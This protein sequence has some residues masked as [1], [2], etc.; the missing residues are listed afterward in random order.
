MRT[1]AEINEL[2]AALAKAQ[3]E[4]KPAS[5]DTANTFFKTKY[6]TLASCWDACRVALAS[7]GLAVIQSPRLKHESEDHWLVELETRL[8]H[9]S[10]QWI[11]DVLSV[12]VSKLD[13]QG[14]GSA[15]T[16]ARRYSLCAFVGVAPDDDD[17]GESAVGRGNGHSTHSRPTQQPKASPKPPP[18]EDPIERAKEAVARVENRTPAQ[19]VEAAKRAIANCTLAR[20][21]NVRGGIQG[22]ADEGKI[23]AEEASGL[24]ALLESRIAELEAAAAASV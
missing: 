18:A 11:E 23:S 9:A 21:A 15:S 5:K 7:N 8:T 1:S 16:Y 22:Y 20:A 10:G 2:S 4:I 14:V 12:P 6:A 13:A 19:I 3:G 17:D 24:H